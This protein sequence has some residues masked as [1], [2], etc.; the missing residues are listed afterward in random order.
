MPE[1][2]KSILSFAVV[3]LVG[4]GVNF[5]LD[6]SSGWIMWFAGAVITAIIGFAIN[7]MIVLGS[8]ERKQL[9]DMFMR[10]FGKLLGK[11]RSA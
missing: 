3:V 1:I 2:L 7:F 4:F 5:C 8:A 10:K 6:L 11:G 9:F